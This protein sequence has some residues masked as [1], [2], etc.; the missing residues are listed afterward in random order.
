MHIDDVDRY[1]ITRV[2]MLPGFFTA[3]CN[4]RI[5]AECLIDYTRR[6]LIEEV[7]GPLS[8]VLRPQTTPIHL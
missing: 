1:V 7:C 4:I 2:D 6:V 8:K 3:F 5:D